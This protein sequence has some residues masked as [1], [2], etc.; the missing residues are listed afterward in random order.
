MARTDRISTLPALIETNQPEL[1]NDW[2]ARQLAAGTMRRDLISESQLREQSSE[3]LAAFANA[4]RTGSLDLKSPEWSEVRE[5]L[6]ELSRS[7]ARQGFSPT[8]TATFIFSMKQPLFARAQ[9]HFKND[10]VTLG[11]ALRDISEV[12]D[13]LGLHTTELSL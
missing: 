8:E 1:L 11:A 5:L 3:F 9:Q 2:L 12:I 6:S 7:R 13:G 4:A 10:V